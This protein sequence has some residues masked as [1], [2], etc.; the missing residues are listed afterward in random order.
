[1][2]TV[3]K[4]ISITG[5]P[6][7]GRTARRGFTL[8]E[9][10]VVMGIIGML[11]AISLPSLTSYT[12]TFRIKTATREV[13]GLLSLARSLAISSRRQRT[14]TF[15]PENRRLV[16]DPLTETEEPRQVKLA[17]GVEMAADIGGSEADEV[18]TITFQPSGSLAHRA[19]TIRISNNQKEQAI[20]VAAATGAV[21]IQ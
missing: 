19:V 8:I 6:A 16:L 13:V 20:F 1:M 7:G 21:M 5:R 9:L 12:N 11:F 4:T 3:P 14:V 2:T 15:D 10:L 17:K 18:W